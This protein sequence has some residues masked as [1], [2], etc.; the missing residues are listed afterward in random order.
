M[1]CLG[2]RWDTKL[3]QFRHD[4]TWENEDR[5]LCRSR[6]QITKDQVLIMMNDIFHFIRFTL[7]VQEDF[8]DNFLPILDTA[9]RLN[10]DG[11]LSYKFYEKKS[12]S[13]F[14]LISEAA[15]SEQLKRS[16]LSAEVQRR[17]LNIQEVE[18]MEAVRMLELEK[19]IRKMKLS[20]YG[21]NEIMDVIA[22]GLKGYERKVQRANC[23]VSCPLHRQGGR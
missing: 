23:D 8:N 2:W 18:E 9:V 19:W 12:S 16:V 1:L 3:Q 21:D 13:E 15:L 14:C 11:T 22:S 17:M 7:E 20:G 6:V 10:K 5:T 4:E